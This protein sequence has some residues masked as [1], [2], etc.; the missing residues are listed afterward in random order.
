MTA[1][2]HARV[3]GHASGETS[4]ESIVTARYT[5]AIGALTLAADALVFLAGPPS[6]ALGTAFAVAA[7][8]FVGLPHGA[9]D[10]EVARRLLSAR[11]GRWWWLIFGSA[12][13]AIA[14]VGIGLWLALPIAG[15]V[16]LLVGGAMHWG[17]D[18]LEHVPRGSI[19]Q[20]WLALSRGAISVAAP[21]AF[22]PQ[23]VAEVF[24]ALLGV[25][26]VDAGVVRTAG[27]AWMLLAV[28]GVVASLVLAARVERAS[29]LRGTFE[30]AVLIAWFAAAPPVLAFAVYFCFWHSVRHSI[31]SALGATPQ[32]GL[33]AS[34]R[35]YLLATAMPTV[36]TLVL[37]AVGFFALQHS[38]G[39]LEVAWQVIFV[40]LFALTVPHVILE[41]FEHR[42][43]RQAQPS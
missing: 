5:W 42:A 34:A 2:T 27:I 15:L 33:W 7:V 30:I 4:R 28:P 21:L 11:L 18:D 24:A 14:V 43:A 22:H 32:L 37:A 6:A 16:L 36:L 26:T 3:V 10:L 17:L 8:A 1:V 40:G 19:K 12:Y 39:L 38:E 25:A 29:A 13:L 20:A 23:V 35:R 41:W 31:R 9:Y